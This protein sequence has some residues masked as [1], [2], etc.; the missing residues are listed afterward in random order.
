MYEMWE[1]GRPYL[2]LL[3]RQGDICVLLPKMPESLGEESGEKMRILVTGGAG[4]IGSHL[5]D[6][7]IFE[8]HDVWVIDDLSGGF[9]ENVN[10][11]AHFVYNSINNAKVVDSLMG[12]MDIV[13]HLA[14]YAA[15]GL[16]HFIKHF[17]YENNLIGSINLIN[18]AINNNV[19]RF[20]FTSSMAVYGTNQTPFSE[21]MI[22]NPEDSYGISKYAVEQELKISKEMFGLDYT[23]IRPHNVYGPRQNIG[24]PYRNVIGIFMNRIMQSKSPRIYGDG[25]QTRAFSYI[26]DI[27][28]CLAKS[29]F[30]ENTKGEIINLGAAEPVTINKLAE[31]VLGAMDS[32]LKPIHTPKRY[33][34]KHAYCTTE[35]SEKFLGYKTTFHLEEGI[36]RMA[37][38]AKQAGAR[39]SKFWETFEVKKNLPEFWRDFG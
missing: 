28:P 32:K 35:K 24:D 12:E 4:F 29:A 27:I 39:R 14:A 33:E 17:N 13:F 30:Q 10:P 38:W 11:Q 16:S 25:K 6:Y 20:V 15:E 36:K 34:V 26:D 37:D 9:R 8:G 23:I 31:I 22:P 2:L 5:V 19:K 21:D 1:V 7:L 18:A 3:L